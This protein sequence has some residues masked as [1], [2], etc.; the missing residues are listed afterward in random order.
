MAF[1][2]LGFR[3]RFKPVIRNK[4][5]KFVNA[6]K[7]FTSVDRAEGDRV[8]FRMNAQFWVSLAL[9]VN[10]KVLRMTGR[11]RI[12]TLRHSTGNSQLGAEPGSPARAAAKSAFGAKLPIWPEAAIWRNCPVSAIAGPR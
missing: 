12:A 4:R 1:P 8:V 11:R 5:E 7:E 9:S 10:L 3:S 2:S 6:Y